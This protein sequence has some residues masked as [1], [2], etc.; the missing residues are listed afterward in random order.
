MGKDP[1]FLF[2]DGDAARDVSHM[3][4]LER[5]AYFDVMQAQRKFGRMTLDIIRKV[6]G[7][8]FETVWESLK[9]C[10]SYDNHMYFIEWVENS[11]NK[12]KAY[13][14]SRKHNRLSK[15]DG[16]ML[17]ICKTYEEH[18]ENENENKNMSYDF[19]SVFDR[20]KKS[21]PPNGSQIGINTEN[22]LARAIARGNDPELIISRA[23]DYAQFCRDTMGDKYPYGEF[24]KMADNWLDDERFNVDWDKAE[25]RSVKKPER[26]KDPGYFVTEEMLKK[27]SC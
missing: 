18:M 11:T 19:K 25:R 20:F 23:K 27:V 7:K 24:S 10:L 3:N 5:G 14:E 8:D 12:R 15:N 6:L 17:N 13:S 4:R 16:H 21:Y 9:I 1:A 22:S 26:K 2:Y